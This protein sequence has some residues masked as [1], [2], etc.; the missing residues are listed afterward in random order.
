MWLFTF[1][2]YDLP[3]WRAG[4]GKHLGP[5]VMIITVQQT[6]SHNADIV[7]FLCPLPRPNSIL[8]HYTSSH[9]PIPSFVVQQRIV[10]S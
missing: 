4:R 5:N 2:S 10:D 8:H 7:E 6:T 9:F 3:S 1:N